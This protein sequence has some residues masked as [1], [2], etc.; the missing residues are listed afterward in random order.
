[1]KHL[2]NMAWGL[3]LVAGLASCEMKNE[4]F[5][6]KGSGETGVLEIG[7]AVNKAIDNVATRAGEDDAEE[8]VAVPV[9]GDEVAADGFEIDITGEDNFSEQIIY[10]S[11]ETNSISLPVGTYSVYAHTP[12]EMARVMD[13]PY[14]GGTVDDEADTGT[15]TIASGVTSNAIIKCVMENTRIMLGYDDQFLATYKSWNIT[16]E[17]GSDDQVLS[18]VYDGTGEPP[19][20]DKYWDLGD[21]VASVIVKGTAVLKEGGATVPVSKVL[22]K[23]NGEDF[24]GAEALNITLVLGSGGVSGS[25][26]GV[27]VEVNLFGTEPDSD[28]TV[29]VDIET[30]DDNDPPVTP[31]VE[32]ELS[33]VFPNGQNTATFTLPDQA[34]DDATAKIVAPAGLKNIN[35]TIEAEG[36]FAG[37]VSSMKIGNFDLL[38][39][40]NVNGTDLT[41]PIGMIL[42]K[43]LP[44]DGDKSYDFPVHKF[45]SIITEMQGASDETHVFTVEVVDANDERATATLTINVKAKAEGQE[46]V[47][48]E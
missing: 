5:D 45:F 43:E 26:A 2:Y 12:G 19:V 36:T 21:G 7:V 1:M 46:P 40:D 24:V 18:A 17:N 39:A 34:G 30:E 22:T 20:I 15:I 33:V 44:K 28:D 4:L 25:L 38:H 47:Q 11:G 32:G 48:G 6:E 41:G 16:V 8:G 35:V 13:E 3:L 9:E 37:I 10:N 27:D 42:Q 29:E 14:Y 31:P 23:V